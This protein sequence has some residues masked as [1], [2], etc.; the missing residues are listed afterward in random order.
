MSTWVTRSRNRLALY[1]CDRRAPGYPV[2]RGRYTSAKQT[3]PDCGD[4]NAFHGDEALLRRNNRT[5]HM[6]FRSRIDHWA[7][8]HV[9]FESY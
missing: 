1:L 6:R 2:R 5:T 7:N 4:W 8:M 9:P 3:I